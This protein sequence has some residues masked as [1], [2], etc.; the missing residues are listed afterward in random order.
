MKREQMLFQRSS[1]L[2]QQAEQRAEEI[3]TTLPGSA[4]LSEAARRIETEGKLVLKNVDDRK[5]AVAIAEN[6][7]RGVASSIDP[8]IA[9]PAL[10][11]AA[12]NYYY[13]HPE[14]QMTA[15][16]LGTAIKSS[17]A[18]LWPNV[19]SIGCTNRANS[20]LLKLIKAAGAWE[21][22]RL[23]AEQGEVFRFSESRVTDTH[24]NL[25]DPN[26]RAFHNRWNAHGVRRGMNQRTLAQSHKVIWDDVTRFTNVCESI[27]DGADPATIDLLEGTIFQDVGRSDEF[28][29]GIYLRLNQIGLS[30]RLK[31]LGTDLP[32]WKGIFLFEE[33][34]API[35]AGQIRED[36]V[37]RS[38]LK[39]VE[40]PIIRIDERT[41]CL[42][43]I[44]LMDSIN[45]F[46]E[47]SVMRYVE[48]GA[49]PVPDAVFQ[50]H[51]SGPFESQAAEIFLKN[52]WQAGVVSDRRVWTATG[53]EINHKDGLPIPGEMDVLAI[54]HEKK[55]V[56]LVECK[57]LSAP[58]SK[59]KLA[60]I[61]GK[62]GQK[63]DELFHAKMSK[64]LRWLE[65]VE[66][67]EGCDFLCVLL[68]DQGGALAIEPP[69]YVVELDELEELVAII[70]QKGAE[71][72]KQS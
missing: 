11:L 52:G 7:L 18:V 44:N 1:R 57:V 2:Y 63:D 10:L 72:I 29:L 71:A 5:K 35:V 27:L 34:A 50:K 59:G 40:R 20:Q 41:F 65:G 69:H 56:V 14:A 4:F 37:K 62:L 22:L 48:F 31:N 25:Y 66:A 43:I 64:K 15:P 8:R 21:Q 58:M 60:N 19:R 3:I 39:I 33:Y 28:W 68:V 53:S 61:A 30:V 42:S 32:E 36:V 12:E 47:N 23:H 6:Y 67:L 26:D 38:L 24:I 13:K 17:I 9:I 46:I 16:W 45:C 54:H 55:L 49:A 51:I 70:Q